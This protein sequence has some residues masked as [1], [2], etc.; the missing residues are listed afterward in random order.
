MRHEVIR[1]TQLLKIALI[2]FGTGFDRRGLDDCSN[3]LPAV[4]VVSEASLVTSLRKDGILPTTLLEW[5]NDFNRFQTVEGLHLLFLVFGDGTKKYLR[6][7]NYLSQAV[8]TVVLDVAS[9]KCDELLRME[10]M[11]VIESHPPIADVD[12]AGRRIGEAPVWVWLRSGSYE[13]NCSL[14]GQVFKPIRLA[15]PGTLRVLCQ[16]ENTEAARTIDQPEYQTGE[17]KAGSILVYVV[18]AAASVAAVVVPLLLLF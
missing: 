2:D 14:P 5:G 12:L 4:A 13:V 1:S 16:R 7:V 17:E 15:V 10:R 11:V 3:D 8:S 18:A 9:P 6:A